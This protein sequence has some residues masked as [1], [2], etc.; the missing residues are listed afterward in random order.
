MPMLNN[1]LAQSAMSSSA[2]VEDVVVDVYACDRCFNGGATSGGEA[3]FSLS[4]IA[5]MGSTSEEY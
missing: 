4:Q 2:R 5:V 3:E 1:C